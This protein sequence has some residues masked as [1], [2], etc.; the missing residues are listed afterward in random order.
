MHRIYTYT[1]FIGFWSIKSG[2]FDLCRLNII[3]SGDRDTPEA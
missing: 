3:H 1:Y 2:K